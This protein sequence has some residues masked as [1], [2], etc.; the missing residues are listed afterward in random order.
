M[1]SQPRPT[2]R[3]Q[4]AC[5]SHASPSL[6][7]L[8]ST[9]RP[10][11]ALTAEPQQAAAPPRHSPVTCS[12]IRAPFFDSFRTSLRL[13][14]LFI[15]D[16]PA[17]AAVEGKGRFYRFFHRL[18]W[19]SMSEVMP[20]QATCFAPPSSPPFARASAASSWRSYCAPSRISPWPESTFPPLCLAAEPPWATAS[21]IS[22]F[23]SPTASTA[24]SALARWSR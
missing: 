18:P 9:P 7:I 15:V 23:A 3:L 11:L 10:A 12:P 14:F 17:P 2:Q 22:S 1:P 8:F 16:P 4:D 5:P 24:V 6:S 19:L 21:S 13:A 20:V